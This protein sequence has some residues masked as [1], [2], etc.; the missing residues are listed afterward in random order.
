MKA[1]IISS[2]PVGAIHTEKHGLIIKSEYAT[3][4]IFDKTAKGQKAIFYSSDQLLSTFTNQ[5]FHN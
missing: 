3:V 5:I 1:R 4:R 2:N